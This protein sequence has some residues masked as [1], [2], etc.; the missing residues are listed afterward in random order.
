LSSSG[1]PPIETTPAACLRASLPCTS[2]GYNL[3]RSDWTKID[4]AK[5]NIFLVTLAPGYTRF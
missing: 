1:F 3:E 2:K 4:R 5:F